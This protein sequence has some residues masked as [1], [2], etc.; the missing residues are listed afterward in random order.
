MNVIILHRERT[1]ARAFQTYALDVLERRGA[2]PF[3]LET[4]RRGL[5]TG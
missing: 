5:D 3:A 2:E 4:A 1:L